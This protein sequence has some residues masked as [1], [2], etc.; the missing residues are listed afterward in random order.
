MKPR[1]RSGCGER[2]RTVAKPRVAVEGGSACGGGARRDGRTR[3]IGR[4]GDRRC[5]SWPTRRRCTESVATGLTDSS[6]RGRLAS[7]DDHVAGWKGACDERRAR[8]RWVGAVLARVGGMQIPRCQLDSGATLR[9]TDLSLVVSLVAPVPLKVVFFLHPSFRKAGPGRQRRR[10]G[11][12]PL[13]LP[14]GPEASRQ[15][16]KAHGACFGRPQRECTA[17][18]RHPFGL[19]LLHGR[20]PPT[21]LA[22]ANGGCCACYRN[23]WCVRCRAARSR[24]ILS[25]AAWH[26]P[27]LFGAR[28][29][30]AACAMHW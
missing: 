21:H 13:C 15:K 8:Q 25:V 18:N 16:C 29:P 7:P 2:Q 22:G 23:V 17:R 30:T 28:A 20:V 9:A 6:S 26:L 19:L 10:R 12:V 11:L 4:D 24:S 3:A 27:D 14:H 1:S 5:A